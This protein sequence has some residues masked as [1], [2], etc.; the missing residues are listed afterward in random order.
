M[1]VYT[2]YYDAG[3]SEADKGP[4]DPLVIVGLV[5]TVESWLEFA[6]AWDRVL[7]KYAVPHLHMKAFAQFRDPYQAWRGKDRKRAA[8]IQR[9]IR[10]IKQYTNR[11][12]VY[13]MVP[14]DFHAVNAKY[15]LDFSDRSYKPASMHFTAYPFAAY[16]CSLKISAWLEGKHGTLP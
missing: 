13:R 8:F 11:T 5:G 6:I 14:A 10:V 1:A 2:V 7:V 4:T 16:A 12:F 15:V 9:L 3:G